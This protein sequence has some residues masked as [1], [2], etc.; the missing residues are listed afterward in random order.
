[1]YRGMQSTNA[2]IFWAKFYYVATAL[3]P[4]SLIYFAYLFPRKKLFTKKWL[5]I[6]I[7]LVALFFIVSPF[8][9]NSIIENVIPRT[10]TENEIFF[11]P[12]LN[13]W[14]IYLISF[15]IIAFSLLVKKYKESEGIE[16]IQVAYVLIGSCLS[17]VIGTITN[18]IFP[19]YLNNP[20]YAWIGPFGTIIMVIFVSYSALKHHLFNVKIIATELITF[21]IWM[22]LLVKVFSSD[23]SERLFN[24]G[25][26]IAVII[27]GISLIKSVIN[28]VKQ[29]EEVARALEAEKKANDALEL[30]MTGLQHDIKG[31]LTPI[32]SAASA[33]IDGSGAF[34]KLV[35]G[36]VLLNENGINLVKIFEKSAITAKEQAD[37]FMAIAKFRQGKPIVSLDSTIEL[38]VLLEE[39][40]ESFKTDV[41]SKNVVLNFEKFGD[42]FLVSADSIKLKSAL[43]NVIGNSVKYT[44]IGKVVVNLNKAENNKVLI[45]V[46]DTG[47]GIPPDKLATLFDSPFE[48]TAEARKTAGG[49]G[50][51]LYF[52]NMVIGL[53]NGN[54]RVESDGEDKGSTFYIELPLVKEDKKNLTEGDNSAKVNNVKS[55]SASMQEN[56]KDYE[57]WYESVGE[58]WI[59]AHNDKGNLIQ[60]DYWKT[61]DKINN[62]KYQKDL[63]QEVIN[64][65]RGF[66]SRSW[67][68]VLRLFVKGL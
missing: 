27:F 52:A 38:D 40:M 7:F 67:R 39:L 45:K 50:F 68:K 59:K 34:S 2:A 25:I 32:T 1:M 33:L 48:R 17:A 22:F 49:S 6:I 30:F 44:K 14:G 23:G 57:L 15:F 56:K 51:G 42:K 64:R 47:I 12:L 9:A 16:K 41:N 3:I 24:L 21:A 61:T 29:K 60:E 10:E 66:L 62:A 35:K 28:E 5:E 65:K 36:G 26:F 63:E 46:Q 58:D 55:S 19:L 31:H 37:D 13:A 43:R 4:V 20:T 53:H 8:W 18:H 11:G 54:I